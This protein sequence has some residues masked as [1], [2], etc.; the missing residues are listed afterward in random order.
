MNNQIIDVILTLL[1]RVDLKGQEAQAY[2]ACVQ[3][4]QSLRQPEEEEVVT[5][6]E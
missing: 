3:A 6:S 1:Q 2:M 5:E 4:L